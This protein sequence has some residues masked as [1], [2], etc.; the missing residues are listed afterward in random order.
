M[1]VKSSN[2]IYQ[3]GAI[4]QKLPCY[5]LYRWTGSSMWCPCRKIYFCWWLQMTEIIN[6]WLQKKFLC[7]YWM[8]CFGTN[9]VLSLF[10]KKLKLL[11]LSSYFYLFQNNLI[12]FLI[13]KLSHFMSKQMLFSKEC[14]IYGL[15]TSNPFSKECTIYQLQYFFL[16]LWC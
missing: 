11:I 5:W 7:E 1:S 16:F 8:Y 13:P 3:L 12:D 6:K 2:H 4:P 10:L 15:E 14:W 9:F